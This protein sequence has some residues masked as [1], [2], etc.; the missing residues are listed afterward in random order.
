[1]SFGRGGGAIDWPGSQRRL[2]GTIR[3]GLAAA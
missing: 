2:V 1:M 3:L